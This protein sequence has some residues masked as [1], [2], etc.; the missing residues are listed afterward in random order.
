M[1]MNPLD[2]TKKQAFLDHHDIVLSVQTDFNLATDS[3]MFRREGITLKQKIPLKMF[4]GLRSRTSSRR[5]FNHIDYLDFAEKKYFQKAIGDL[6]ENLE[7]LEKRLLEQY[8]N[9]RTMEINLFSEFPRGAGLGFVSAFCSLLA[10]LLGLYGHT[11]SPSDFGF[12]ET[13]PSLSILKK[14]YRNLYQIYSGSNDYESIIR[15]KKTYGTNTYPKFIQS[16]QPILIKR[17]KKGLEAGRISDFVHSYFDLGQVV[18]YL[19]LYT[20]RPSHSKLFSE[21]HINGHMDL[22]KSLTDYVGEY[23]FDSLVELYQEGYSEEALKRFLG[24]ISKFR[25]SSQLIENTTLSLERL[26]NE[27]IHILH[28]DYPNVDFGL[29]YLNSSLIGGSVLAVL[30]KNLARVHLDEMLKKL[31]DLSKEHPILIYVSWEDGFGEEGIRIVKMA[32][33]A[34]SIHSKASKITLDKL[35]NK[36]YING[37]NVHSKD[38]PSQ[39][40]TIQILE[41]LL[42][43]PNQEILN[44]EF[45]SS[46]YSKNK[47]DMLSKI[48]LPFVKL[49]QTKLSH[50]LKI[51]CRGSQTKFYLRYQ[52]SDLNIEIKE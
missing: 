23:L 8:S 20:G 32:S 33:Q 26:K 35:E 15:G 51:E 12:L 52:P 41:I 44:T 50:N 36:I 3:E 47:Y 6:L 18:D 19:I 42:N 38:L 13:A 1:V 2:A 28:L 34:R 27:L 22:Q 24:A 5:L 17:G 14:E 7:G 40:Q 10:S 21:W 16:S 37:E 39:Y 49:V 45:N 48:I 29:K 31:S 46:S 25:Y 4:V 9:L 43:R 30:S 11:V